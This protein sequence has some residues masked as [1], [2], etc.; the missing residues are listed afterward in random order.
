[1]PDSLYEILD[2][3]FRPCTNGDSRLEV[4][5]GANTVPAGFESGEV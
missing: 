1:M 3:R 4:L 2:D 5:H